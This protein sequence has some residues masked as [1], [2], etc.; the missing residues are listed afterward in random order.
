LLKGD[1]TPWEAGFREG[2]LGL[3]TKVQGRI[4]TSRRVG[5]G[6][7]TTGT[8]YVLRPGEVLLGE[9]AA[10]RRTGLVRYARGPVRRGSGPGPHGR[11]P[12]GAHWF[13]G[14]DREVPDAGTRGGAGA[15]RRG[16]QDVRPGRGARALDGAHPAPRR[17]AARPLRG[18]GAPG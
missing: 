9:G 7:R 3:R 1:I 15:A 14:S 5:G 11:R 4:E 2:P 13:A 17:P 8:C 10:P 12:E 18:A 6:P 16:A